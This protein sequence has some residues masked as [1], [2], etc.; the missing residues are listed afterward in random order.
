MK[1]LEI[2]NIQTKSTDD[3]LLSPQKERM[4]NRTEK[5]SQPLSHTLKGEQ[6]TRRSD[7]LNWRQRFKETKKE[8]EVKRTKTPKPTIE[9]EVDEEQW[10]THTLNPAGTHVTA[11]VS[12]IENNDEQEDDLLVSFIQQDNPKDIWIRAKTNLA[13]DLA[14]EESA[15][16]KEQTLEE[17]VPKELIQYRSVFDKDAANRFPERRSWDHAIDLQPDFLPKKAHVYPLSLPEQDK[18]KEFVTENLE[19]G[20]IRPSKSP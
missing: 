7:S 17:M 20:Y 18:L 2:A 9:E 10:K 5:S 11:I 15:K 1:N 13:M 8:T 12:Q 19:K 16:R 4:R 6:K 3:Q 14:I